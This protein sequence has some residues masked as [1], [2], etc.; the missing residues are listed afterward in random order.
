MK[1]AVPFLWVVLIAGIVVSGAGVAGVPVGE[2]AGQAVSWIY[3][4]KPVQCVIVEESADRPKL[5]ASQIQALAA[6]PSM[7]VF[8][9]D[10][11]VL[12]PG[13]KPAPV[14]QHYLDEAK[15][16]PLPQ[17]VRK[18]S[19]GRTTSVDCPLTTDELRKAVAAK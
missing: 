10:K 14:L 6:A 8:V 3:S 2:Y 18:W 11:D 5:P 17:L 19:S 4:S 7:G 12:G 13:K 15:G 9:I 16:K 1:K